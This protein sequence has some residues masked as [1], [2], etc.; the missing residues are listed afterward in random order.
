LGGS[1]RL[2]VGPRD[3]LRSCAQRNATGDIV[4]V[5]TTTLVPRLGV[6]RSDGQRGTVA[7][8]TYGHYA[9]K[10]SERSFASNT[11]VGNPSLVTYGYTGPAGQGRDF[12]PGMNPANYTTI[13][14]AS[15]P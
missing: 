1:P 4:T 8:A 10:Y 2:S 15:F 11:D 13:I 12:A 6:T 9:G 14:N 5:D 3:A 7:Q